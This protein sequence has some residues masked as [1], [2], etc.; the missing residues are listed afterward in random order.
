MAGTTTNFGLRYA[1]VNDVLSHT[2]EA[3]LADDI[4][5]DLTTQDAARTVALK[6]PIVRVG[7]NGYALP[8]GVVT[9]VIWDYETYDTHG[10]FNSG[11]STS[12]LIIPS[13]ATSGIWHVKA[14]VS[15]INAS[16]WTLFE[17]TIRKNGGLTL[18][19]KY[20][21]NP[22]SATIEGL[23]WLGAAADYV[24]MAVYHESGGSATV[25][26]QMYAHQVTK[27]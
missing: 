24:D 27:N 21:G 7:N 5:V 12:R 14:H 17:I 19:R 1:E 16:N 9:T 4:A 11:V 20:Y 15:F 2:A 13:A 26:S 6:R 22:A 8:V 25:Q 23:I 3:N 10:L 18:R